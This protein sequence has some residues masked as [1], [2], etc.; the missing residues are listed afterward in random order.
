LA[1]ADRA[2][3]LGD[4][5]FSAVP[6]GL[7]SKDYAATLAAQ[8][9]RLRA[10]PVQE[11]GRPSDAGTDVFGREQSRHTTH[12]STADS[13]GN[14]VGL[15]ATINTSFGSKVTVPGTG[16][17][18]NNQMDDFAAQPGVPNFFGLVGAEANSIA[19]GKR[20]LSS[21][22]PTIVMRGGRPILCVGAAG[23]PTIITQT[24]LAILR[25]VDFGLPV[26]AALAR[27]RFHHQWRPDEL[28]IE[29]TVG[30]PVQESL[31]RM[32]HRVVEES[33]IGAAQAVAID[34]SGTG[35]VGAADPRGEGAAG[36]K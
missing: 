4:P 17:L 13:E 2:K 21:M 1:F 6:R 11:A 8:I 9:D 12:L 14:W 5:D 28:H 15:T 19:G 7:I 30:I 22:S 27:P 31:R 23:G 33:A 29:R 25:T 16:V 35:F 3:W 18:L 34:P 20:P 10:T 24:V 36:G 26:D 32:G